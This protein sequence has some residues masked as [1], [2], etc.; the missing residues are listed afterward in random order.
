[1]YLSHYRL[2]KKPF[3]ISPDSRFLWLGEKHR[4]ALASLE[5]GIYDNKG[6][7][8]LTGN[9]GTGKTA[10]INRLVRTINIPI[11]VA[12]IPD[13]GLNTIDF[14]K[15]LANEF[16]LN[17]HFSSKDAF[18]IKI[19]NFLQKAYASA[20]NVLL[21]IDE[22][23]RLNHVLLEEI[24]LLSNIEMD[25]RKL[26]NIFFVG[27]SEFSKMLML[28]R[29][30]ATRQRIAVN[31]HLEPL[32][33]KET[34]LYILHR[35]RVAG[36]NRE[37]F[38]ANAIRH[39]YHFTRGYPRLINILCDR[40]M[41][42]G[43]SLELNYIDASIISECAKELQ[44]SIAGEQRPINKAGRIRPIVKHEKIVVTQKPKSKPLKKNQIIIKPT[45]KPKLTPHKENHVITKPAKKSTYRP[46]KKKNVKIVTA[47][48]RSWTLKFAAAMLMFSAVLF[49]GYVIYEL[50]NNDSLFSVPESTAAEQT[51]PVLTEEEEALIEANLIDK[52]NE[53][54][55]GD[56][57][58]NEA[59]EDIGPSKKVIFFKHDSNQLL[60][61]DLQMLDEIAE[62]VVHHPDWNIAVEGYTD[63]HGDFL[64]NKKLSKSRAEIVKHYFINKG[65]SS[66][67]I[68][69]FGMGQENPIAS[70]DT[71]EGREKNRRVE[72]KTYIN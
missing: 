56:Y 38:R 44:I 70:N 26:I 33:E 66:S 34:G 21:I 1:M 24:R 8:V 52:S 23:Q 43:F 3:T 10:L 54:E 53:I 6:F 5:Y 63:S 39:I 48:P 72:I 42:T 20:K 31:Y 45:R 41:L 29:N 19:K 46:I 61:E 36:T 7:L 62:F 58:W 71:P 59:R 15:V 57:N 11:L 32:T 25:D 55:Q 40:S 18:L 14:Y 64:Y 13:P 22:A 4:E 30:K 60:N 28:E 68:Q 12:T 51:E 9:I 37:I 69:V 65:I 49:L 17:G 67:K 27:Q 16:K 35:L 2:N 47:K 50:R